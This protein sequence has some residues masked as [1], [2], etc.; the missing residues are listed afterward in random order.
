MYDLETGRLAQ[1]GL[2]QQVGIWRTPDANMGERGAKSQ[3]SYEESLEMGTHALNLNDQIEHLW[4]TPNARV[5][6]GGNHSNSGTT[7]SNSV[8]TQAESWASPRVSSANGASENEILM[9]IPH[10]RLE[11]QVVIWED[12]ESSMT[13]TTRDYKDDGLTENSTTNGVL[14]RQVQRTNILGEKLSQNIQNS[15]PQPKKVLNILFAEWLMGWIPLWTHPCS[16]IDKIDFEQWEM[17]L[18]HLLSRLLS[19]YYQEG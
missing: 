18:S 17:E 9:G 6:K 11:T 19:A 5:W 13:P 15:P 7:S 16:H 1:V 10:Q 12:S 3:E 14:G 4:S 2:T 8:A